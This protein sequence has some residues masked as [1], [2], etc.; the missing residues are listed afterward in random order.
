MLCCDCL[1]CVDR[2]AVFGF[3]PGAGGAGQVFCFVARRCSTAGRHGLAAGG[4]AD[5]RMVMLGVLPGKVSFDIRGLGTAE[6]L[7]LLMLVFLFREPPT[8]R[9][10]SKPRRNRGMS[11]WLNSSHTRDVHG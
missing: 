11:L 4:G 5:A 2:F 3:L 9:I 7:L 6:G 1:F 8:I 10:T